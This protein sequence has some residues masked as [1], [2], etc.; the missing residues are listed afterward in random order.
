MTIDWAGISRSS[1]YPTT[2]CRFTSLSV[3]V[4]YIDSVRE[5]GGS[6][7]AH[8]LLGAM[9]H[10]N[11][12]Y[13]E[14]P[15]LEL[16]RPR[17]ELSEVLR[18]AVKI[19]PDDLII[20]LSINIV[21]FDPESRESVIFLFEKIVDS[22]NWRWILLIL[23]SLDPSIRFRWHEFEPVL[24]ILPPVG[25]NDLNSSIFAELL[26]RIDFS[27]EEAAA[28][29]GNV[30]AQGLSDEH[31]AGIKS[32]ALA[33]AVQSAQHPP[34]E[35][36]LDGNR[37]GSRDGLLAMAQRL[38]AAP[39]PQRP[40][41]HPDF[42]WPSGRM[43]FAEFLLQWPCEVE[44]P[45]GLDDHEFIAEAYRAI[46]LRGP[47]VAE[48]RQYLMQLQNGVVSKRWIIED[49]LGSAEFRSFERRLRV[50]WEGGV[51]TEPGRPEAAEMPAVTWPWRS[52]T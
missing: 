29:F 35:P 31:P 4:A 23:R 21:K 5:K 16:D 12:G 27:E 48:T 25:G 7:D 13:R 30:L 8:A 42:F 11:R 14:F 52:A 49:L 39:S 26:K 9:E 10:L 6:F 34:I 28:G 19:L 2:A 3:A 40:N 47:D 18:S 37:Q 41:P 45:V 15:E 43:S 36:A 38:R 51:I 50:S 46:L 33:K 44:L 20:P 17:R 22:G 1:V 32:G 24:V